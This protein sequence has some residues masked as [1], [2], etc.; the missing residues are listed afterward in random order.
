MYRRWHPPIPHRL[1][2]ITGWIV[3]LRSAESMVRRLHAVPAT[4]QNDPIVAQALL[5]AALISYCR[6]FTSGGRERLRIENLLAATPEE[7]AMHEHMRGVRDW[8]IA[9]PVNLQEVHAVHLIVDESPDARPLVK[10][11][12]SYSAV[13]SP[14][15]TAQMETVLSLCGKW[16]EMLAGMLATETVRLKPFAD[17]L[18]REQVLALPIEDPQP[19]KNIRSRRRQQK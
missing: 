1:A 7:V 17:Q 6:C 9:H 16:M 19:S 8:H 4:R 3:D 15:T 10:G 11:I 5:I 2:D 12:S 14:L 18:G 13:S